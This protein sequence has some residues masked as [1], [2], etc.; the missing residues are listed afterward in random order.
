MKRST[1]LRASILTAFKAAM[2]GSVIDYYSG[3]APASADDAL[4]GDNVLLCTISV[5]G[6]G[7][8]VTFDADTSTGVLIK[9]TSEV[10]SGAIVA[11]GTASFF[12]M[13]KPSDDGSSSMALSRL[14][15][16]LG[17]NDADLNL[18]S[19]TFT[20]GNERKLNQ[21]VVSVPAG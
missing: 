16:T 21:F 18:S 13:R 9:N 17:L 1:G 10:W 19:M 14:Q 12:R 2:D 15:G 5:D 4:N 11:S 6:T 3:T 20:V 7:T 8:G